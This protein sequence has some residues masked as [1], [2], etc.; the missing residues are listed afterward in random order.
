MYS[1]LNHQEAI[2]NW[3]EYFRDEAKNRSCISCK[4]SFFSQERGQRKCPKCRKAVGVRNEI[5]K[6][7]S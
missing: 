6:Y 2:D 3:N 5:M 7:C 4:A 1:L